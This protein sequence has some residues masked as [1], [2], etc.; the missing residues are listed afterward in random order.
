M[1]PEMAASTSTKMDGQR[2]GVRELDWSV[3]CARSEW[4]GEGWFGRTGIGAG[5]GDAG[6]PEVLGGTGQPRHQT[7]RQRAIA[8]IDL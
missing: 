4:L 2:S 8:H 6:F 1:S 5:Q 7:R 3:G